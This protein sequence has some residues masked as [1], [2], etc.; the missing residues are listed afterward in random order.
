MSLIE[1][2]QTN[3]VHYNLW[4]NVRQRTPEILTGFPPA[5]L[6]QDDPES[7]EEWVIPKL[8]ADKNM[9]LTEIESWFKSITNISHRPKR[10]TVGLVNDDS[11]VVYY[12]IHDGMVKPRKN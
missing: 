12:F 4:T 8:M 3:L 1:Q 2:V 7:L 5:K 9:P 10:I 11:T 6:I